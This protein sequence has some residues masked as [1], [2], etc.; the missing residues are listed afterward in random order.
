MS[1]R[2]RDTSRAHPR[3][4]TEKATQ[5]GPAGSLHPAGP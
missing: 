4:T 3:T 5:T 1:A 2:T